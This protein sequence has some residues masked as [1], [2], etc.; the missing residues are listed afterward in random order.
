[1]WRDVSS[2]NFKMTDSYK[3][4]KEII[5]KDTSDRFQFIGD[6]IRTLGLEPRTYEIDSPR[7]TDRHVS[8]SFH[9]D[10]ERKLWLTANYDTFEN[11]PSSNNNGSAVVTLL[12]L[13]E[14]LQSAKLPIG[15]RLLFLDAGLDPTLAAKGKR[16]HDFTTGSELLLAYMIE[17][18]SEFIDDYEGAITI[19]A[20]GKGNLCV[21]EKTGKKEENS[22][23]LNDKIVSYAKSVGAPIEVRE[24][25][26]LADN[27]AF[28]KEGLDAT[29]LARYHEGSWHRMQTPKDDISNVNPQ[30]IDE[31]VDFIFGFLRSYSVKKN[32]R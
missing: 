3:K 23:Y 26:P 12:S 10:N 6:E 16:D 14:K 30:T 29:V 11:Y 24:K 9:Y 4:L 7:G 18:E 27:L 31:T 25:S 8:V 32:G 5:G 15:I 2:Q 17:H 1:M 22:R 19:Q 28:L 21:F 20:V 13:A